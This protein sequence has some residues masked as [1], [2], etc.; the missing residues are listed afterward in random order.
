MRLPNG[1]LRLA[2]LLS[3]AVVHSGALAT[4]ALAGHLHKQ[5]YR[6]VQGYILQQQAAAPVA[7]HAVMAQ[8]PV[9]LQAAPQA[10]AVQAAPQ[11]P[12]VQAAP[13]VAQVQL[14]AA[15]A[16]PQVAQV[17]LQAVQAPALQVVQMP[18]VQ[19]VQA[20]AVQL[21]TVQ[22]VQ[23]VQAA[24]VAAAAATPA[25]FLVPKHTFGWFHK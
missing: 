25:T 15:P 17:Q 3:L 23:A 24:P 6:V 9:V 16:A 10:P 12:A 21:Q 8:A 18:T 14:F 13:Q 1:R 7:V 19:V 11:A 20:P 5:K 22:T 2:A 4:P